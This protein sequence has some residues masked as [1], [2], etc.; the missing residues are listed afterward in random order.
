MCIRDRGKTWSDLMHCMEVY[1]SAGARHVCIP[2][3]LGAVTRI[4]LAREF[5]YWRG[6]QLHFLGLNSIEELKALRF[7]PDSSLDTGKP[8]R[9]A[10]Q[11]TVWPQGQIRGEKLNMHKPVHVG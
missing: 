3:R 2:Y 6:V 4:L 1:T 10:Q 9:Y 8:L 11:D 7:T 5:S